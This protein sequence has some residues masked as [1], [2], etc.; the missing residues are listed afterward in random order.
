MLS[1]V[2]P[3]LVPPEASLHSRGGFAWWYADVVDAEGSGAVLIWSYGLPFLPGY[4]SAARRGEAPAASARPSVHL[5]VFERG[6][7]LFYMLREV[8]AAES[9]VDGSVASMGRN[10]FSLRRVGTQLELDVEIDDELESIG[11]VRGRVEVRGAARISGGGVEDPD[12]HTWCPLSGPAA[13]VVSVSSPGFGFTTAGAGY[14]DRNASRAPLD[15]LGFARWTWGR[16]SLSDGVLTWYVL[17]SASGEVQVEVLRIDHQGRATRLEGCDVGVLGGGRS[18]WGLHRYP[19]LVL[20]PVGM[21]ELRITTRHLVDD[22]PFYS[23]QVIDVVRGSERATGI[24]EVCV[25]SR[26]D[27]PIH[28]WMASLCV[29]GPE[30][31]SM[32]R[33][34]FTGPSQGRVPRLLGRRPPQLPGELTREAS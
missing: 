11:R 21:P 17:W 27:T 13:G 20:R 3:K 1:L 2:E 5:S 15:R 33:P 28:R 6:R 14:V 19:A 23:R 4:L 12:E 8:D 31:G 16:V 25:P 34:L 30:R 32:W 18:V 24:A 10:Q 29:H 9:H 22:G 26:V 7:P